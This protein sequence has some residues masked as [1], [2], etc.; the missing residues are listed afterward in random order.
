MAM[1][2]CATRGSILWGM[3]SLKQHHSTARP[4]GDLRFERCESP[5]KVAGGEKGSY[6][7]GM[8]GSAAERSVII[9]GQRE[10]QRGGTADD[11]RQSRRPAPSWR[12]TLIVRLTYTSLPVPSYLTL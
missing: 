1:N 6:L 4:A 12:E 9:A 5:A 10:Q 3:D 2:G 7:L 8:S 11:S